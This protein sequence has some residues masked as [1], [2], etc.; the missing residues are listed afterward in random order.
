MV[1]G[2]PIFKYLKI[3]LGEIGDERPTFVLDIVKELDNIH[4][5]LE[6]RRRLVLIL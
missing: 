3:V 5:D 4:I 2:F 6:G 1:C